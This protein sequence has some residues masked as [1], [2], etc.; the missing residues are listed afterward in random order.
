MLS[1]G[2]K[3]AKNVTEILSPFGKVQKVQRKQFR[4]LTK[5]QKVHATL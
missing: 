3:R 5:V 2:N 4:T 1:H